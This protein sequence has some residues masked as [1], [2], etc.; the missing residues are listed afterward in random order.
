MTEIRP[1]T[2]TDSG[3]PVESDE[4]SLTVGPGGRSFCRTP[5]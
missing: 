3:A 1:A 5:T 4:H 2:T